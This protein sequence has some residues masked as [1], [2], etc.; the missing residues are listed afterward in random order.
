MSPEKKRDIEKLSPEHHTVYD[1]VTN[2]V[3]A[4]FR[5]WIVGSSMGLAILFIFTVGKDHN[6][7]ETLESDNNKQDLRMNLNEIKVDAKFKEIDTALES[8]RTLIYTSVPQIKALFE[9]Q[10]TR[11]DFRTEREKYYESQ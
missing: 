11:R 7:I 9:K 1:A 10:L 3:T 8:H 5:K 6:R 2:T 4:S